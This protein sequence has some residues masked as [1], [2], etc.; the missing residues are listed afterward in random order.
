M[1]DYLISNMD[2]FSINPQSYA[3]N[4]SFEEKLSS[5]NQ[6]DL[7]STLEFISLPNKQYLKSLNEISLNVKL[8]ILK[9]DKTEYKSSDAQQPRYN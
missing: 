8:K 9:H 5:I 1:G 4:S 3:I 2:F 7:T 6:I